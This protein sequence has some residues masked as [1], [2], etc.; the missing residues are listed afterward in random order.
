MKKRALQFLLL[1]LMLLILLTACAEQE[2]QGEDPVKARFAMATSM[3]DVDTLQDIPDQIMID[4][5]VVATAKTPGECE[6]VV[7]GEVLQNVGPVSSVDLRSYG[8]QMEYEVEEVIKGDVSLVGTT[9]TVIEKLNVTNGEL[10]APFCTG[11]NANRAVLCLRQSSDG[12]V[13]YNHIAGCFLMP[14]LENGTLE[15]WPYI[16]RSRTI[17]TLD[18]FKAM[19]E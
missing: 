11:E 17:V 8:A 14:I 15:V 3:Y 13:Y 18:D 5:V 2:V 10:S 7:Q 6:W 9:I 12:T 16:N 19:Y 4:T 1:F